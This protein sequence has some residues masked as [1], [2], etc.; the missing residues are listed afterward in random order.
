VSDAEEPLPP[1]VNVES[2]LDLVAHVERTIGLSDDP[3]VAARR[4]ATVALVRVGELEAIVQRAYNMAM[5][6]MDLPTA[7]ILRSETGLTDVAQN[8]MDH[9]RD[10]HE[11]IRALLAAMDEDSIAQFRRSPLKIVTPALVDARQRVLGL[12]DMTYV[13]E[14]PTETAYS[15]LLR[16]AEQLRPWRPEI[17]AGL[18]ADLPGPLLDA[19]LGVI[20]ATDPEKTTDG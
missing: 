14:K 4:V 17:R 3:M 13:P 15:V 18:L 7:T 16:A 12:L 5:T 1:G 10:L 20:A 8:Y 11:A 2:V 19:I 6:Q 9:F